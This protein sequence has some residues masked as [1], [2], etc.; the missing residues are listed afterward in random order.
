M[1]YCKSMSTPMVT[2]WKNLHASQEELVDPTFYRQL[3]GSLIYM[4]NSSPDRCF[5]V[6]T[7]I[8]FMVKPRRVHW[9]SAKHVL[10]YI[11]GTVD[12]GLYYRRLDGVRLIG[13]MDSN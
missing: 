7:L 10:R 1:D 13:F 5:A 6:N 12:Y 11:A 8:Q 2:K 4:V 9:V 3:I